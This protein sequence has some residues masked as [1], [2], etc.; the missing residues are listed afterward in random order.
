MFPFIGQPWPDKSLHL[1]C[2]TTPSGKLLSIILADTCRRPTTSI[3]LSLLPVMGYIIV[4][5]LEE[6]EKTHTSCSVYCILLKNMT[7][8][9]I[10]LLEQIDGNKFNFNSTFKRSESICFYFFHFN[11]LTC[12]FC[13][14]VWSPNVAHICGVDGFQVTE[15]A[16]WRSFILS[17]FD[18]SEAFESG[19]NPYEEMNLTL[20]LGKQTKS[21]SVLS[22]KHLDGTR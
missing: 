3:V 14:S 6:V 10:S 4:Q 18:I 22:S 21:S 15:P 19:E 2:S 5:L 12:V 11:H 7:R 8:K 1:R 20:F 9:S 16:G 13:V 17:I